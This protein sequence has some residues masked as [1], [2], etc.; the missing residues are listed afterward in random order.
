MLR[1]LPLLLLHR[2]RRNS[3]GLQLRLVLQLNNPLH[4][5]RQAVI[6]PQ[7]VRSNLG[8]NLRLRA[9]LLLHSHCVPVRP[10][11]LNRAHHLDDRCPQE[12]VGPFPEQFP[13][14][15]A[16]VVRVPANPCGRNNPAK[17]RVDVRLHLVLEV[18]VVRA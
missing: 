13:V 18:P 1:P 15:D 7:D 5:L 12:I 14:A 4:A 3:R 9:R 17:G 16:P 8:N 10:A 2:L 11:Q 6:R